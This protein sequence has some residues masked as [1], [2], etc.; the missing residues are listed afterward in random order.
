MSTAPS[1]PAPVAGPPLREGE[2]LAR[3]LEGKNKAQFA[4]D[5]GLCHP[6]ALYH[7]LPRK[8]GRGPLR[9]MTRKIAE[10]IVDF[11]GGA[12]TLDELFGRAPAPR[13]AADAAKQAAA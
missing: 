12:L 4:R 7:L 11:T 8:D 5:I 3:Y 6:H 10:A 1:S 2:A 13:P 9:P